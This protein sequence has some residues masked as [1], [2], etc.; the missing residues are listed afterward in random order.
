MARQVN[1]SNDDTDRS[2]TCFNKSKQNI[3]GKGNQIIVFAS[4]GAFLGGLIAQVPGAIAGTIIA[5]IY[6]TFVKMSTD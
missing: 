6:G 4:G 2:V 5:A 1:I 3:W